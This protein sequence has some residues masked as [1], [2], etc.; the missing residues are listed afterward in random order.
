MATDGVHAR[1]ADVK[2]L[3]D[4]LTTYQTDVAVAARKVQGA[5][6]AAD[7]H[8]R[9]KDAF[10]ARYRDLQKSIDRFLSGEVATMVKSLKELARR[11]EEIRSMRM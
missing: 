10:E 2:R 6:N 3:A 4:A 5:L 8:D 11:L 9:Q 1:P 7:W